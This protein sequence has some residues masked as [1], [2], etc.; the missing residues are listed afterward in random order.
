MNTDGLEGEIDA[1]VG[2]VV[3]ERPGEAKFRAGLVLLE[4][5]TV[6][7]DLTVVQVHGKT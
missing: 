1:P 5:A 4:V 2:E 3:P 6:I 7:L